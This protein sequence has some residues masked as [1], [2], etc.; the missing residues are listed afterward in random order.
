MGSRAAIEPLLMR[1]LNRAMSAVQRFPAFAHLR[2]PATL[3]PLAVLRQDHLLN[4]RGAVA[5][6]SVGA[7]KR[8]RPSLTV[9]ELGS[10]NYRS[11]VFR[12]RYVATSSA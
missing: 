3:I 11:N 7:K 2:F 10:P 5:P 8:D 9:H 12:A 4:I 6:A 1:R